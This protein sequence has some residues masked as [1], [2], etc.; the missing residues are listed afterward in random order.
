MIIGCCPWFGI[1]PRN[2]WSSLQQLA[3]SDSSEL[4][5]EGEEGFA[6][7]RHKN[8]FVIFFHKKYLA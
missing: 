4:E 8:A 7:A 2:P 5:S 3:P 6:Q 1:S